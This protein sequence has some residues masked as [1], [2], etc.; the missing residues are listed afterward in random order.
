MRRDAYDRLLAWKRDPARKPLVMRG[1]RQTGK[2]YLLEVKAGVN[3]KSKSLRSF[4]ARF[5]PPLLVRSTLLNLKRDDRVLNVPL[6]AVPDGL[7]FTGS[8]G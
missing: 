5:S 4:D 3:P 1:A 8:P 6:Y 2:T 7:S